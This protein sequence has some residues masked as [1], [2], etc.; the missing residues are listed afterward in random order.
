MK[1]HEARQRRPKRKGCA[2]LKPPQAATSRFS[3]AFDRR[4]EAGAR[5][6][7]PA[8]A[9]GLGAAPAGDVSVRA[10]TGTSTGHHQDSGRER[11]KRGAGE[12][13]SRAGTR[14]VVV[15]AVPGRSAAGIRSA[16][17]C[18]PGFPRRRA[19]SRD[20]PAAPHRRGSAAATHAAGGDHRR[21][22][23]QPGIALGKWRAI[24]TTASRIPTFTATPMK[25]TL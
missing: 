10:G 19:T 18:T 21:A 1:R 14:T 4:D 12:G 11:R 8:R 3:R 13:T 23:R 5:I 15:G 20:A 16:A 9:N 6:R 2:V 25:A 24:T 22:W 17:G 7:V